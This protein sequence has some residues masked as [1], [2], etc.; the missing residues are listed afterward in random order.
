M[1]TAPL[2][3][4]QALT[5]TDDADKG[6]WFKIFDGK[7]EIKVASATSKSYQKKALKTMRDVQ[8]SA[9]GKDLDKL[10]AEVLMSTTEG[11]L[12]KNALKGWATLVPSEVAKK[13]GY[14]GRTTYH[15]G[16]KVEE[17]GC[18]LIDVAL[19]GGQ[20]MECTF[21]NALKVISEAPEFKD[22]VA[23]KSNDRS[24][25]RQGGANALD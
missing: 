5:L 3:D 10:P 7:M 20:P 17:E 19:F 12:A 1:T 23:E 24:A 8:K 13:L 14:E 2:F 15:D 4:L 16:S 22:E 6:K 25:F 21:E 11:L 18:V 9:G